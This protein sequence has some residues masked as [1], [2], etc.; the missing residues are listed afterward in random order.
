[1][2][3]GESANSDDRIAFRTHASSLVAEVSD[4]P[5]ASLT[6]GGQARRCQI[7]Q[8]KLYSI[9]FK[10]SCIY[11]KSYTEHLSRYNCVVKIGVESPYLASAHLE[12]FSRI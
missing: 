9:S 11:L 7:H 5:R 10:T 2:S 8:A 3:S 1:M 6:A 12:V 4:R